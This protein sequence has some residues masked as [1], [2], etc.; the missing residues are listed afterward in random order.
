MALLTIQ[1]SLP[2]ISIPGTRITSLLRLAA[3]SMKRATPERIGRR[4]RVYHH[5]RVARA[6]SCNIRRFRDWCSPERP[7]AFGV[8]LRAARTIHGW[9]RP[10]ANWRLTQLPSIQVIRIRFTSAP[11]TTESWYQP[12]AG[13][14]SCLPTAASAAVLLTSF[15]LIAKSQIVSMPL[16]SIRPRAAAFSLSATMAGAHGNLRCATCRRV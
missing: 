3:A 9:S 5:S 1:T 7:K 14:I 6:Q 4:S 16:R 10:R 13:R 11:T 8:P 12:M 2:S 15:C